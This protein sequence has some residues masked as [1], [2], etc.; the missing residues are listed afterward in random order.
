MTLINRGDNI[1]NCNNPLLRRDNTLGILNQ[2]VI[3][4]RDRIE[5]LVDEIKDA[6]RSNNKD[7][8]VELK[9]TLTIYKNDLDTRIAICDQINRTK[10][11]DIPFFHYFKNNH[12]CTHK[13]NSAIKDDRLQ[14]V[15]L[16]SGKPYRKDYHKAL[17]QI[18][19]DSA[20]LINEYQP[21]IIRRSFRKM[22]EKF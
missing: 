8:A 15:A 2:T 14:C 3:E 11:K 18:P 19:L 21:N 6:T 16:N 17:N 13:T 10:N 7:L 9:R 1:I 22:L 5:N 20:E 4:C 12:K